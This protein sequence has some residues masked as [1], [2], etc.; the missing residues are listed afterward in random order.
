MNIKAQKRRH[1]EFQKN[2]WRTGQQYIM[3]DVEQLDDMQRLKL[4]RVNE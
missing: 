3:T 2:C 4:R 1:N